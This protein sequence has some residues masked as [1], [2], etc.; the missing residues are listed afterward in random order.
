MKSTRVP[1]KILTPSLLC[2]IKRRFYPSYEFTRTP[3]VWK[4]RG[5]FIEFEKA[6]EL[7]DALDQC[8]DPSGGISGIKKS[9]AHR[10]TPGPTL[11]D[12]GKSTALIRAGTPEP[13]Q[14]ARPDSV[15]P[16]TGIV[17]PALR[18][19]VNNAD[20]NA[21][22]E[23]EPQRLRDAKTVKAMFEFIYPFWKEQVSKAVDEVEEEMRRRRGL[24]RFEC[25]AL[26]LSYDTRERQYNTWTRI[27]IYSNCGERSGS[28]RR[29][30]GV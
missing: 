17:K 18:N 5:D 7:E 22:A 12:I 9:K 19:D 2:R 23:V 26:R 16:C 21:E 10:P 15:E 3:D 27:R 8:L 28:A 11:N 14:G 13:A 30:K 29:S 6:L 20:L 25:G 4:T 24:R 1:D